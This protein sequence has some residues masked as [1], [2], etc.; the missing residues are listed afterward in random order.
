MHGLDAY[1]LR[2]GNLTNRYSSGI[3]QQNHFENAFVNRFNSI[4][5][6]G[7][8]PHSLLDINV[9][10]TPVDFASDAILKIATHF[11]NNFSVFHVL[12]DNLISLKELYKIFQDLNIPLKL[13]DDETFLNIINKIN[14][15]NSDNKKYLYDIMNNISDGKLIYDSSIKID[16]TFTKHFL[17]KIDFNWPIINKDYIKKYIQYFIDIGYFNI[18]TFEK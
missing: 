9:E 7:Y 3:F 4:L 13:V 16:S 2:I 1:I 14:N 12:N 5:K 11:N 6:I 18:A 15:S 17:K 10:F 8:I